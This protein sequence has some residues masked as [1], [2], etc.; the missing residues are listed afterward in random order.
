MPVTIPS[1]PALFVFVALAPLLA[2]PAA[3]AEEEQP[4]ITLH[5]TEL[6]E[7]GSLELENWFFFRSGHA[8]EA[9]AEFENRN[10]LEYGISENWQGSLYVLNTEWTRVRAHTPQG[11]AQ[12]VTDVSVAGELIWRALDTDTAP[13]GLAFYL[14]PQIGTQARSVETKILLQKNFFAGRLRTVINLIAQDEWEHEPT[15]GFEEGSEFEFLAGLAWQV[16]PSWSLALEFGNEHEFAGELLGTNARPVSNSFYLGPTI[17]YSADPLE[18]TLGVQ[19]QL[20]I[21]GNPTHVPGSVVD[22]FTANAE[23]WRVALRVTSDL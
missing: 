4:F 11:P 13:F 8:G 3:R 12:A 17:Q 19:T 14:E 22:G 10:E 18:I 6:E 20:P 1:R 16:A 9:F 2:S 7:P 23:H 15:G 5:T 21:A